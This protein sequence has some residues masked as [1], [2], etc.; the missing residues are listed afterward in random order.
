MSIQI[1]KDL[2]SKFGTA[3]DQKRRP[4]CMAFAASD[5]H[6]VARGVPFDELSVEFAYFS[7]LKR[8][9][10][11]DPSRGVAME[12][13]LDA[14]GTIGQPLESA[15]PYI[16]ILPTNL[17]SY[18]PPDPIGDLYKRASLVERA[19]TNLATAV[20]DDRAAMLGIEISLEFYTPPIGSAIRAGINSPFVGKHAVVVVGHGTE[21]GDQIFLIRNSWGKQWGEHG[22]A[23]VSRHYLEPRLITLGVYEK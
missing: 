23:W 1:H 2:R 20:N 3:R 5:A 13:M 15:W 19:L 18:K 14:I 21:A 17:A 9:A 8:G 4:T 10:I 6:A 22:Y 12:N 16:E 11:F 7:A